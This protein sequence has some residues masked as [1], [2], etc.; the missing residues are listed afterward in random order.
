MIKIT[1]RYGNET[2]FD[3]KVSVRKYNGMLCGYVT[4][5][6]EYGTC[7]VIPNIYTSNVNKLLKWIR[8]FI[9]EVYEQATDDNNYSTLF[10][11]CGYNSKAS[12]WQQL[13][14]QKD[15]V[16]LV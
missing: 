6:D 13:Q 5:T 16:Y 8:L 10:Y 9:E 14:A 11:A 7:S 2:M 12:D 1:N 3:Y 4:F 15:G